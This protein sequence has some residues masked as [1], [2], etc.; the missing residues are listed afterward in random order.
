MLRSS[1]WEWT[2]GSGLFFWRWN[3]RDQINKARDGIQIFVADTLPSKRRQKAV[4]LKRDQQAMVAGKL[5]GMVKCDYLETGHVASIVHFFAA[6]KLDTDIRVIFNGTSSGLN[7]ALWSPNFLP[8][9]KSVSMCLSFSM[10]ADMDFGEMFHNFYMDPRICP[11]SGVD[12]GNMALL[13]LKDKTVNEAHPTLL[14][15]TS[16]FMGMQPSSYNAVRHYY[17]GEEFAKGNPSRAGN[18]MGYDCVKLNLPAM[19]NYNPSCP[20]VMK[21]RLS[22]SN[23]EKGHVAG[24]VVTFVDNVRIT[25][26]S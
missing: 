13:V 12:L 22:N 14:R 26:Y 17:W 7:E 4:R 6:P 1:W 16:L 8:S 21:W 18:P 2:F 19:T 25:G 20:K 24:D 9:A 10:W 23:I 15:W 5:E 11:C 3:S